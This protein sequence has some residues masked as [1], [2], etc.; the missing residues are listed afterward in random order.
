L[1]Q[2]K[3]IFY[4]VIEKTK[5][6]ILGAGKIILALSI[7]LWF[8]ASNGASEYKNAEKFVPTLEENS[9]LKD[10]ALQKKIASYKL[11]HSYIGTMGK[12]IEPVIAPMGYD[13]KIGIALIS[14]FA[15]RE[16]FVGAL[17][18]IYSV[19]SEGEDVGTIKERMATEVNPKTGL[20]RFNLATGMS[21]LLF[22][23]FAM[24]CIGTLAIVKR[25]TKSW[26]WPIL[27]L[28]G[29]GILAYISALLAFNIFN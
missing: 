18:T 2:L 14:S 7:V 10:E 24:Q 29:M 6:F 3:N 15:A 11:E 26:K 12:L 4:E 27:Q 25:E 16:V 5:A 21:L 13:W 1:Y 17:A 20:K 19:E 28:L 8:L 22:Y 9:N 23:A